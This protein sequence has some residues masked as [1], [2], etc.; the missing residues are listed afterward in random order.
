MRCLFTALASGPC[1]AKAFGAQRSHCCTTINERGLEVGHQWLLAFGLLSY[2]DGYSMTIGRFP[3]GKALGKELH[4]VEIHFTPR[5]PDGALQR[6]DYACSYG[7]AYSGLKL[8]TSALVSPGFL[9]SH[10]HQLFRS[11]GLSL[12]SRYYA[13]S[14]TIL[15]LR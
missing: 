8:L 2:L 4:C 7:C 13:T 1:K 9:L 6:S 3:V 5:Y 15:S 11:L 10:S 14:P 12:A